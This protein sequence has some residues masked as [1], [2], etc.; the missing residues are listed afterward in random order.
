[1][2][3]DEDEG[4]LGGISLE[5][6]TRELRRRFQISHR[7]EAGVVVTDVRRGSPAARA[8]VRPGD[9]IIGVNRQPVKTPSDFE[10]AYEDGGDTV[11]LRIHRGGASLFLVLKK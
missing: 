9:V 7:V 1:M 10:E 3:I 11:L 4:P 6:L 8:G 2:D 5:P